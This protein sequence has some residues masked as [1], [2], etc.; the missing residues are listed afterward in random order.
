[1]E[2]RAKKLFLHHHSPFKSCLNC[3]PT[4]QKVYPFAASR[5]DRRWGF[6][7]ERLFEH[8]PALVGFFALDAPRLDL[9]LDLP[10]HFEEP[11]D[12]DLP[13]DFD[14]RP[15]DLDRPPRD[16]DRR[17]PQDLDRRPPRDLDRRPPRD[18]LRDLDADEAAF[19]QA[20]L[21]LDLERELQFNVLTAISIYEPKQR[22]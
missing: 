22:V 15:R 5:A 12:L 7:P 16:F 9:D 2:C 20:V 19:L 17:P 21:P 6:L 13:P 14:R 4:F 3:G 18:L 11:L 1:M 8:A 10:P